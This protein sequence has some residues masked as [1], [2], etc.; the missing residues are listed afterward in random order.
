MDTDAVGSVE[1]LGAARSGPAGRSGVVGV[2][3]CMRLDLPPPPP[4]S[5]ALTRLLWGWR[6]W[7]VVFEGHGW[8]LNSK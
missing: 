5:E 7:F 8:Q 6:G 3:H 4:P 1:A 2:L